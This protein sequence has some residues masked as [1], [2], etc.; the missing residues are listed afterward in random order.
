MSD[1]PNLNVD[2]A[3]A[4]KS[5]EE[6]KE[7]YARWAGDYDKTFAEDMDFVMPQLAAQEFVKR[8]GAVPVIDLGAG[9]GLAG[10]A[11]RDLGVAP[12]DATDISPEMLEVARGKR[13]YRALFGGDLNAHLPVEDGI[14]S[15]VISTGTFTTGHVGPDALDE[16]LRILAPGGWAVITVRDE[17]FQEAGFPAKLRALGDALALTDFVPVPIYGERN[18]SDHRDATGTLM[19]LRKA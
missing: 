13:V 18:T 10:A 14:Y 16:V 12:I 1:K 4:L 2:G 3:Y 5:T 7:F 15:G 19:V 17:H 9:T 11:L 6:L 8:G